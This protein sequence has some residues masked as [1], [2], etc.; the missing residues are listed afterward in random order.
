MLCCVCW[1]VL[2]DKTYAG[3]GGGGGGGGIV[4]ALF[5]TKTVGKAIVFWQRPQ[6]MEPIN[7]SLTDQPNL[8]LEGST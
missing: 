1:I 7:Q 8:P 5:S 3:S 4:L 2:L 6:C